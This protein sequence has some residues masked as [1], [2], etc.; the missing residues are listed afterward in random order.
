[1]EGTTYEKGMLRVG[2]L[3]MLTETALW[4]VREETGKAGRSQA[5]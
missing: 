2:W 4:V 5:M 1:M 3:L